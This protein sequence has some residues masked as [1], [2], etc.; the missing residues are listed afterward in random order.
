MNIL[1]LLDGNFFYSGNDIICCRFRREVR[2]DRPAAIKLCN[3]SDN[4]HV[5]LFEALNRT[6]R[7]NPTIPESNLSARITENPNTG[8]RNIRSIYYC[9][10]TKIIDVYCTD[11]RNE[12][13]NVV[14]RDEFTDVII[15]ILTTGWWPESY[16]VEMRPSTERRFSG[17]SI[18]DIDSIGKYQKEQEQ[19]F[20]DYMHGD[21]L[22]DRINN[23]AELCGSAKEIPIV[24]RSRDFTAKITDTSIE[25]NVL[26]IDIEIDGAQ[27]KEEKEE[28]RPHEPRHSRVV[29]ESLANRIREEAPATD[30]E[31]F[32]TE[33]E[34]S[35]P[36]MGNDL[37]AQTQRE[38]QPLG[39]ISPETYEQLRNSWQ[40]ITLNSFAS[41]GTITGTAIR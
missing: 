28:P 18:V 7:F 30:E 38:P 29:T 12:E 11:L 41:S 36:I 9:N 32:E 2:S 23:C 34:E 35:T 1:T 24:I 19:K 25:E 5:R 8:N 15:S 13:R 39:E 22:I 3:L 40:T 16:N 27:E 21:A 33:G 17:I 26:Y 37:W 14:F 20:K 31:V 6:A 10:S 4:F